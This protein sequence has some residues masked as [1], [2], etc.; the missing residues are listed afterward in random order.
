[1]SRFVVQFMK[2]VLGDN[3]RE[4]EVCQGTLEIDASSEGQATEMAKLKFCEQQS[5]CDWS[6][7]A[8]RIR[9]DAADLHA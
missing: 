2:D 7:H 5:L 8:D 9:I 4:R 3:G 6:L 1:M